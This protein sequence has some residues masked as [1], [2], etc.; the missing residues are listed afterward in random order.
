MFS[1]ETNALGPECHSV[2]EYEFRGKY[3]VGLFMGFTDNNKM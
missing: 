3:T 2:A 1:E